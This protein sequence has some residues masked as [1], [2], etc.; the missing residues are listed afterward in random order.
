MLTA[1]ADW[2]HVCILAIKLE[3]HA[4]R[5]YTRTNGEYFPHY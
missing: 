4:K 3:K 5:Q 1:I 2:Y